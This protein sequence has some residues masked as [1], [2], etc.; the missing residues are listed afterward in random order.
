M[1]IKEIS[2]INL[3]ENQ[4]ISDLD[5]ELINWQI[6]VKIVKKTYKDFMSKQGKQTKLMSLE[7]MDKAGMIICAAMF[8]EDALKYYNTLKQGEMYLI[9]RGKIREDDYQH[10]KSK[11][12]S[13]YSILLTLDSEF[14]IIKNPE[15]SIST[16]KKTYSV[17][18]IIQREQFCQN[19]DV[20]AVVVSIHP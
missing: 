2:D 1:Q 19:I 9:T 14:K 20:V 18:Q 7:L 11:M 10:N 17:G 5:P 15:V 16:Q 6:A 12:H 13:K 8:G 3:D 4:R